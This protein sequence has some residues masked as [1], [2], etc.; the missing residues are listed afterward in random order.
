M[1]QKIFDAHL[2]LIWTAMQGQVTDIEAF[3]EWANKMAA[4]HTSTTLAFLYP[5]EVEDVELIDLT[6]FGQNGTNTNSN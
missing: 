1:A 5:H 3:N 6:K 2:D 4:A